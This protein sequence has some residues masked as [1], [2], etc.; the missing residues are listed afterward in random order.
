MY[1]YIYIERERDRDSG[2]DLCRGFGVT[3]AASRAPALVVGSHYRFHSSII[4]STRITAA[5]QPVSVLVL[6]AGGCQL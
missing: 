3:S 6:G 5:P 2:E 1:I 4:G